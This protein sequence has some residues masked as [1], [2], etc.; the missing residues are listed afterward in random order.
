MGAASRAPR[1]AI[2]YMPIGVLHGAS[3]GL[4][5]WLLVGDWCQLRCR[6]VLCTRGVTMAR[7]GMLS[8]PVHW[9]CTVLGGC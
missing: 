9:G 4:L 6:L 5:L 7:R 1:L 8:M 3:N 2:V